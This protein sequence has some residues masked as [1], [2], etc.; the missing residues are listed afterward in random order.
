[1]EL[2]LHGKRA[3]VL[4]VSGGLGGAIARSLMAEG[5]Q[6]AGASRKPPA[7]MDAVTWMPVDAADRGSVD[8]LC[9]KLLPKGVTVSIIVPGRIHTDR[10]RQLAAAAAKRQGLDTA[11]VEASSRATIPLGR[12]GRPEEFG[13]VVAFLASKQASYVTGCVVRVDGGLIRSV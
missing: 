3:L 10:V 9:E 2:G 5:V 13:N 7:D 1:M 12:Y 11:A 4:G 8:A 6:V